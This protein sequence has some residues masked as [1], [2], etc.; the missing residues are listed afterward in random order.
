MRW[1]NF[2]I[3]PASSLCD[4]RCRYCFYEDEANNRV[5]KSMGIM[6]QET[7][8]GPA[9]HNPQNVRT[10]RE[11]F[12]RYVFRSSHETVKF[13]EVN[14]GEYGSAAGA[15]AVALRRFFVQER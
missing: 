3:K 2:L 12:D 14:V 1:I 6:T 7:V 11:S 13:R 5:Q 9:F 8:S 10:V 15:C 4:L